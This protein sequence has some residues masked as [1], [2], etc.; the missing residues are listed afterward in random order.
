MFTKTT[1]GIARNTHISMFNYVGK[2]LIEWFRLYFTKLVKI[3][4]M[5]ERHERIILKYV[6]D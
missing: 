1:D 2:T 3:K 4:F 5:N 6:Y